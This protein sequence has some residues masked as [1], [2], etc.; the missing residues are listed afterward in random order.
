MPCAEP[1]I[2]KKA[3]MKSKIRFN[4]SQRA[5]WLWY[6]RT[7]FRNEIKT[8]AKPYIKSATMYLRR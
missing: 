7:R 4:Q 8:V 2:E 3:M 6:R 1:M 5:R